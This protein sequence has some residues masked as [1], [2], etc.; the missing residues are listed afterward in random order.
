MPIASVH[1]DKRLHIQLYVLTVL[2][3]L[4]YCV[5]ISNTFKGVEKQPICLYIFAFS[6]RH[7]VFVIFFSLL[8]TKIS[9]LHHAPWT[10]RSLYTI[11]CNLMHT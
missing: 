11:A 3:S 7:S 9:N 5:S 1:T 2:N 4:Y 6:M 8:H 10:Y